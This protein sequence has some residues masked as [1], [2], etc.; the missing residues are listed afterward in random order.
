MNL[1]GKVTN[2]LAKTA[3]VAGLGL[4][5]LDAHTAGKIEA[6]K[7]EKNIKTEA[8]TEHYLNDMSL[9]SP[10]VVK[11]AVKK[12]I[13]N[14]YADEHFTDFFTNTG[15][16]ISGFSSMLVKNVVPFGLAIGAL[17]APKGP[18]GIITKLF[19][20]GLVVYGGIFLLQEMFGIGKAH[21]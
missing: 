19:G 2:V 9:D 18:K 1:S 4:V 20:A 8:L 21:E 11:S 3:G 15:G 13:F 17:F 6:S 10:S 14:F 7:N 5:L 16:Y 12:K